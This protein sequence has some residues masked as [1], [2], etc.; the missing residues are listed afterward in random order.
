MKTDLK[1]LLCGIALIAAVPLL[2]LWQSGNPATGTAPGWS[3][4]NVHHV[5]SILNEFLNKNQQPPMEDENQPTA[6]DIFCDFTLDVDRNSTY[7]AT[8]I[9]HVTA[10]RGD[11][12]DVRIARGR[13]RAAAGDREGMLREFEA[14]RA[15][16][17]NDIERRH[18][19]KIVR[20]FAK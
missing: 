16:A 9:D 5:I 6:L 13:L 7:T 1:S 18:V 12:S 15:L 19:E 10:L 14:A 8:W 20:R 17:R 2:M 11:C 4:Y 3:E